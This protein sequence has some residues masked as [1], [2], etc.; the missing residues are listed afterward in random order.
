VPDTRKIAV[1]CGAE[2]ADG[3]D[4]AFL[5]GA[6]LAGVEQCTVTVVD[7]RRKRRT[8][9]VQAPEARRYTCFAGSDDTCQ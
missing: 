3:D 6:A 4:V 2:R 8:A 5:P 1:Q 9:E 7:K